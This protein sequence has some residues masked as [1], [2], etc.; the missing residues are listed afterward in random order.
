MVSII[1]INYNTFDLTCKCIQS[2]Y[3]YTHD[4]LFEIILV[5]NN[6]TECNPDLFLKKFPLIK[7]IKSNENLGFSKG[8]NLGI[9]YAKGDVILLLNSDTELKENSIKKTY[10]DLIKKPNIGATTCRLVFQNGEVQSVCQRFPSIFYLLIE[11]FRLHKF[12]SKQKA[13]KLLLGSFFDYKES[14]FVDW[15]WG[16]FFM[17]RASILDLMPNKKLDDKFFMYNEDMQWCWDIKK[18]GYKIYFNPKTEVIHYM[19]AS[20]GDKQKFMNENYKLFLKHNYNLVHRILIKL[21]TKLV[22]FFS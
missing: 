1:I 3:N 2:I 9:K 18:L 13:G 21:L 14:I 22:I 10:C 11:L 12:L 5:D 8:N 7:L 6:S 16:T 15:V 19:G 4:V 17:F 20:L